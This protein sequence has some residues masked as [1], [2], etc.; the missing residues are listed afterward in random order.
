MKQRSNLNQDWKRECSGVG[1]GDSKTEGRERTHMEAEQIKLQLVR[2]ELEVSVNWCQGQQL[3]YAT[4]IM[5]LLIYTDTHTH[6]MHMNV[7]LI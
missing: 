2:L 7:F 6:I 3:S 4:N 5:C 1:G